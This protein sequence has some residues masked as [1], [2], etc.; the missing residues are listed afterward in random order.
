MD[1]FSPFTIAQVRNHCAPTSLS[2]CL[3]LLGI[4]ATQRKLAW[5]AGVPLKTYLEGMDEIETRRAA[6]AYGVTATF[7]EEHDC[8]RG[9]KFAARLRQHL[10]TGNPAM[11]LV[12]DFTHWISVL[13]YADDRFVI[14]DPDDMDKAFRK[15]SETTLLQQAWNEDDDEDGDDAPDQ[16]FAILLKRK[17]GRPSRWHITD[18]WLKLCARGSEETLTEMARDIAEVAERAGGTSA[19]QVSLADVLRT[20]ERTVPD[21]VS[22][23]VEADVSASD[24]RGLYRDFV[25]TADSLRLTVP[26]DVDRAAIVAQM[27]T[28]LAT[29]TWTEEL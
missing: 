3:Y 14:A 25:I 13:G 29:W 1:D 6:Q 2:Y 17:D 9:P 18:D 20:H 15:W 8:D 5:A 19:R 11:L 7:V 27:T 22:H 10:K 24:L 4:H 16:Y 21:E 23:W 28:I 12:Y 26:Q